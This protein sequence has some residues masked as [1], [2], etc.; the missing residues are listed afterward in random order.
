[1]AAATLPKKGL[2]V[3]RKVTPSDAATG[4]GIV[5]VKS[6]GRPRKLSDFDAT[7]TLNRLTSR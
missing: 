4:Y 2:V 1:M 7:A 6:Q 3:R 5:K